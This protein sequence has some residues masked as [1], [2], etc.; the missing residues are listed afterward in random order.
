MFCYIFTYSSLLAS[1][2]SIIPMTKC[3][4]KF[5]TSYNFPHPFSFYVTQ[6]GILSWFMKLRLFMS[7]GVRGVKDN[8]KIYLTNEL[9]N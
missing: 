1:E 5:T 4:Y 2:T 7:T 9:E 3:L 6:L 8:C